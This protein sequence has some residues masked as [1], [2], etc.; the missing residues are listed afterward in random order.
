M[1]VGLAEMQHMVTCTGGLFVMG[2]TYEHSVLR[3]S[4]AALLQRDASGDNLAWNG[5][6]TL[7]VVPGRGLLV[8]GAIG[9]LASMQRPG[10]T[11]AAQV[12]LLPVFATLFLLW[13]CGLS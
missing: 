7:E 2:E 9:P 3:L 4:V 1:Q 5:N 13:L 8:A 10:A 12:P 6:A 11:A